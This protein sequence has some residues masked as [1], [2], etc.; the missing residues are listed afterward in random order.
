MTNTDMTTQI[1]ELNDRDF[2]DVIIGIGNKHGVYGTKNVGAWLTTVLLEINDNLSLEIIEDSKLCKTAAKLLRQCDEISDELCEDEE[3]G[4]V[5][6]YVDH[7]LL[8]LRTAGNGT[9]YICYIDTFQNLAINVET[10]EVIYFAKMQ[11]IGLI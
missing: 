8:T 10:E 11:D 1:D 3:A 4:A 9:K 5:E 2:Y 7:S 6:H